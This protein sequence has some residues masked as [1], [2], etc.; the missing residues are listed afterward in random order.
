MLSRR[1]V[2]AVHA[3]P[4]AKTQVRG[5]AWNFQEL[6]EARIPEYKGRPNRSGAELTSVKTGM[7]NVSFMTS[8]ELDTLSKT[9]SNIMGEFAYQR[10]MRIKVT[11]LMLEEAPA[12]L[13]A[14][15]TG[16]PELQSVAELKALQNLSEYAGDLL[17][18]QNQIVQRINDFVES[19]PVYLLDQPLR[20]EAR[21]NLLPEMDNK[22]RSLIRTELRDWLPGEYKQVRAVDLQQSAAHSPKVKEDMFK[23][24]DQAAKEAEAE[25][26]AMPAAEQ[27]GLM[28]VLKE[29][30]ESSKAFIDPTHDITAASISACKDVDALREMAHRVTEYNG[31]ARLIAIYE[32]AAQMT[33]DTAGAALIKE[34]KT[35]AFA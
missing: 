24:I 29:N 17:E 18:G 34:I 26:K 7:P 1:T 8:Y 32:K 14:V 22:T 28:A 11:E 2:N 16:S 10:D 27:A 31:D 5:S 30:V 9:R 20:E 4:R 13:A 21:W 19:N 23:A 3:L 33:G 6:I 25:I 12:R 15:T 35:A